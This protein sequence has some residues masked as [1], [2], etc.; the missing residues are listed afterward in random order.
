MIIAAF[1]LFATSA[2]AEPAKTEATESHAKGVHED[3]SKMPADMK[4]AEREAFKTKW[5]AM[6]PDEKKAFHEERHK[7]RMERRAEMKEKWENATP[8]EREKMKAERKARKEERREKMKE[9]WENATPEE[10][11]KMK[12]HREQRQERREKMKE[13]HKEGHAKH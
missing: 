13:V 2:Y 6:S 12:A 11:E 7:K 9:K 8:E 3:W 1:G 5:E 10:R 4:G